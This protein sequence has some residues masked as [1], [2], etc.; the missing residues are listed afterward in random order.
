MLFAAN[1]RYD[2]DRDLYVNRKARKAF[3][4]EFVDDHS[5]ESSS[6]HPGR[7]EGNAWRFYFNDKPS[8]GVLRILEE[9]LEELRYYARSKRRASTPR[10]IF[11]C[12]PEI[13]R[14]L[15]QLETEIRYPYTSNISMT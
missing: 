4:L 3:S 15:W 5:E 1:Y 2:F 8:E 6:G 12:L 10:R 13:R 7:T 14:V 11:D 9:Y